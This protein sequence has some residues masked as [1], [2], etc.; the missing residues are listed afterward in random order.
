[1]KPNMYVMYSSSC[2]E[3]LESFSTPGKPL[4]PPASSLPLLVRQSPPQ[5]FI[6]LSSPPLS[7]LLYPALCNSHLM[8]DL[9]PDLAAQMG[10]ASFGAQPTA[11]KR[12]YNPATDAVTSS[13]PLS[14]SKLPEKPPPLT[15]ANSGIVGQERGRRRG[16]GSG[17]VRGEGSDPGGSGSGHGGRGGMDPGGKVRGS[18]GRRVLG[19]GDRRGR[20]ERGGME[21]RWG[22]E[23]GPSG[24][25]NTPLGSRIPRDSIGSGAEGFGVIVGLGTGEVEATA[26]VDDEDGMPGYV[27]DTPPGSPLPTRDTTFASTEKQYLQ[28]ERGMG[29]TENPREDVSGTQATHDAEGPITSFTLPKGDLPVR[30]QPNNM[31]HGQY[32]WA[33]LRRGVRN[34]RG[35]VAYYDA[36]FVEDPWKDLIATAEGDRGG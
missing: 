20:G 18:A 13:T 10:F 27:D 26:G 22:N 36:S 17:T 4:R 19:G 35:D 2:S 15:G 32:D 33:A 12:R 21:K 16:G 34:E 14:Y 29:S 1:M 7:P 25:N 30:P 3:T 28:T 8:D 31:G 11:K 24:S 6:P 9:D 23:N 5:P